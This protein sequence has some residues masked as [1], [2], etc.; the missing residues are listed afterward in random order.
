LAEHDAVAVVVDD[1][2]VFVVAA[3]ADAAWELSLQTATRLP[4]AFVPEGQCKKHLSPE[5]V[6][7]CMQFAGRIVP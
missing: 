2:V 6:S 5:N 1:D 7:P 4:N 3:A